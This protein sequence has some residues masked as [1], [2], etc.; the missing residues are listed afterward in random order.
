MLSVAWVL[1]LI[2]I[3]LN[4]RVLRSDSILAAAALTGIIGWTYRTT[5]V[6][7]LRALLLL[8]GGLF[9]AS[10]LALVRYTD[11]TLPSRAVGASL[12]CLGLV[13]TVWT[14]RRLRA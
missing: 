14:I 10:V 12:S 3:W 7:Q 13:M 4:L 8:F 1:I 9:V 6:V 5:P 11:L 2:A